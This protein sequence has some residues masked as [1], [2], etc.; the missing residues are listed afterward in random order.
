MKVVLAS[1]SPRRI[2]LMNQVGFTSCEVRKPEVDESPKKKEKPKDMVKRL[3]L[4][5]ARVIASQLEKGLGDYVVIAADTTVVAPKGRAVLGK[6]E[7]REDA[8]R[9]LK[10]LTGK[11]HVVL[12]GYAVIRVVHGVRG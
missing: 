8:I 1:S 9:M 12:T 3:A 10:S 7:S 11:T 6:P 2:E 5:K 4:E